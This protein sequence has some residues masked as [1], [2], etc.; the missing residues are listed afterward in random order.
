MLTAG[1]ERWWRTRRKRAKRATA[2]YIYITLA[3]WHDKEAWSCL[4][5]L[6]LDTVCLREG[7]LVRGQAQVT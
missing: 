3:R 6:D 7:L 4:E 5:V 2:G 1:G